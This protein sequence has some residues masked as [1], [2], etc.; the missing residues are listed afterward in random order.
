MRKTISSLLLSIIIIGVS[1]CQLR[2]TLVSGTVID[3]SMN[4]LTIVSDDNSDTLTFNTIKAERNVSDGIIIG[5]NALIKYAGQI[6]PV[7]FAKSITVTSTPISR[8]AGIWIEPIP[9]MEDKV[10]GI[11][12]IR[13]GKAKS[14]NM[15]T[16][17]YKSW[18]LDGPDAD[19]YYTITLNGRSIGN[20]TS[21]DFSEEYRVD[22]YSRDSLI[23]SA[24]DVKLKYKRQ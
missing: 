19:G 24:G 12:L 10:Q 8:I 15:N 9:G 7:T 17:L 2:E 18:T 14:V 13:G 5:D 20:D 4:T 3:A 16:L 1:S 11:E 22:K 23:L 6:K 21:F